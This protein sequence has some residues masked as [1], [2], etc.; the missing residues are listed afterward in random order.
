MNYFEWFDLPISF[1][2]NQSELRAKFFEKSKKLHPDRFTLALQEVQDAKLTESSFN[3]NA[4]KTLSQDM[5]G[6]E[7]VFTEIK[8]IDLSTQKLRPDFLMEMMDVNEMVSEIE[9]N[10]TE[11]SVTKTNE[12]INIYEK[13]LQIT[14]DYLRTEK[15]IEAVSAAQWDNTIQFYL[16]KKYLLRIKERMIKFASR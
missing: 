4:Y 1:F 2:C 12:I 7:Y 10:Y 9:E 13:E 5:S 6:L 16:Q 11:A 8:K 15:N 3:T 14:E